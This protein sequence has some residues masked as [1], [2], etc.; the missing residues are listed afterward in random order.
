MTM[1]N[2]QAGAA[3]HVAQMDQYLRQLDA[4]G[5]TSSPH[6]LEP[7]EAAGLAEL[8]EEVAGPAAEAEREDVGDLEAL[9]NIGKRSLS[10]AEILP[11]LQRSR[12]RGLNAAAKTI[13]LAPPKRL[14][15]PAQLAPPKPT[16]LKPPNLIDPS[17]GTKALLEKWVKRNEPFTIRQNGHYYFVAEVRCLCE[18]DQNTAWLRIPAQTPITFFDKSVGDDTTFLGNADKVNLR[19][20]NYQRPSKNTYNDQDFLIQSITMR[21]AGL[22]VR[23]DQAQINAIA[24]LGGAVNTLTGRGWLWDDGGLFLPKEIFNDFSGEN[25]LYRALRGSGV[26]FFNW[27][28]RRVG[29]NG[30]TRQVLIDNV[31]SIPDVREKKLSRTSGGAAVLPVPDG[32]V[33]TDNPEMSEEGQFTGVMMLEDEVVFPVK[34]IQLGGQAI[35]PVEVGL[36]VQLS[37]N[38]ISF[39]HVRRHR[40]IQS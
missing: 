33:F 30:T 17:A 10:L 7:E 15:P 22:R 34:P 24:N 6:D 9:G 1:Q 21:E 14:A 23:Y 35:K 26:L 28:K 25:L 2:P 37:L 13:A 40:L 39:E 20:T 18:G 29:G 12:Q 27:E 32:Y 5:E 38:G 16:A 8:G 11:L 3:Q 31:E 19:M 4:S 36:Y